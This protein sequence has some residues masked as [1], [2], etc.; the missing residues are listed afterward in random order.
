MLQ[1]KATS[2]GFSAQRRNDGS[3]QPVSHWSHERANKLLTK[4]MTRGRILLLVNRVCGTYQ[5]RKILKVV[6]KTGSR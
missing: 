3:E 6:G 5:N 1:S 4:Q 2:R